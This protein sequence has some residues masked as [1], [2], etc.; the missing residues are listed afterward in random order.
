MDAGRVNHARVIRVAGV[1]FGADFSGRQWRFTTAR[2]PRFP[3][4]DWLAMRLREVPG[5]ERV[6]NFGGVR[7]DAVMGKRPGMPGCGGVD[8]RE[9]GASDSAEASSGGCSG[10]ARGADCNAGVIDRTDRMRR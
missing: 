4:F 10:K 1:V 6:T 8:V 5:T 2:A 7:S 3:A 9:R